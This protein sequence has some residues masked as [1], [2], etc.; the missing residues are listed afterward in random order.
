LHEQ[1]KQQL[2]L[3]QQQQMELMKRQ[4]EEEKQKLEQE[5]L[6]MQR[7]LEQQ[8]QNLSQQE[9]LQRREYVEKEFA[10]KAKAFDLWLEQQFQ[11][12]NGLRIKTPQEQLN[13]V[14]LIETQYSIGD[15]HQQTMDQISNQAAQLGLTTNRFTQLNSNMLKEKF[16]K[17]KFDVQQLKEQ[18]NNELQRQ[19]SLPN[20]G[21]GM[22]P[23]Q[24]PPQP[25]IPNYSLGMP[26]PQ[27]Q[28]NYSLGMPPP[29]DPYNNPYTTHVIDNPYGVNHNYPPVTP[30]YGLGMPQNQYPPVTPS[31]GLGMP[32]NQYPPQNPY[33][34]GY[35]QY[36]Y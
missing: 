32:Q 6:R 33:G 30:S 14:Q 36:P 12:L 35:S 17:L 10:E 20:Y 1:Q 27:Q 7:E 34:G 2:A 16:G 13:G 26:P 5:R 21:L 23:P 18:A 22:P 28:P 19:R 9:M 29:Q 3:Q 24:Q 4:M 25:Q 15:Q 11:T 8:K 31:Y